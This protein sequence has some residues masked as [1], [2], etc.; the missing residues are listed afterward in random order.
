MNDDLCLLKMILQTLALPVTG[1][2]RLVADDGAPVEVLAAAFSATHQSVHTTA[3]TKLTSQQAHALARLEDQLANVCRESAPP[4][5][6]ELAMR[7]SSEWRQV[8]TMAR[9]ALVHFQWP[10]EVP[11]LALIAGDGCLTK[12]HNGKIRRRGEQA[13]MYSDSYGDERCQHGE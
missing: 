9:E 1:Q 12:M 8:R 13:A 7:R 2:V 4:L 3:G 6:L 10:L 11:P 5:A